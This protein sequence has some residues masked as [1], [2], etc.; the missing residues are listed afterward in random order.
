MFPSYGDEPPLYNG[1]RWPWG[2]LQVDQVAGGRSSHHGSLKN[3]G[4][5]VVIYK[6]FSKKIVFS[7]FGSFMFCC[8]CGCCCI[9]PVLLLPHVGHSLATPSN[10]LT[11]VIR[12]PILLSLFQAEKICVIW[13]NEFGVH[14]ALWRLDFQNFPTTMMVDCFNNIGVASPCSSSRLRCWFFQNLWLARIRSPS[15][16]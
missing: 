3:L 8:C 11:G 13:R 14:T 5:T 16:R 7:L 2:P 15:S 6:A 1:P 9:F 12:E 4:E 10:D